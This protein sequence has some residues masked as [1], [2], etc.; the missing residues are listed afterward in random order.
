AVERGGAAG[1]AGGNAGE[2]PTEG[3]GEPLPVPPPPA[4][5][6]AASVMSAA[7][8]AK[9]ESGVGTPVV[10]TKPGRVWSRRAL[11]SCAQRV[12]DDLRLHTQPVEGHPAPRTPAASRVWVV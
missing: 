5:Q 7:P 3:F 10:S 8:M 6:V 12:D 4:P 11:V 1:C 9:W 2:P